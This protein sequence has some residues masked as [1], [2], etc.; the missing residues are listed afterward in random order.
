MRTAGEGTGSRTG[1]MVMPIRCEEYNQV[2]VVAVDGDLMGENAAAVRK[3][4]EDRI[5][6]QH[7]A[8]FVLDLEKCD[9]ADSEG[10]ETLLWVRQKCE[11]LFGQCKLVGIPDNLR[12]ILEI[13]RLD[14]RFECQKD[15]T[16]ALKM[17]R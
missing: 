17:M 6:S 3:T 9:Y 14:H 11:E 2:S 1:E 12:K 16:A 4:V 5:V 8:S 13:T 10:L 15:L 7:I